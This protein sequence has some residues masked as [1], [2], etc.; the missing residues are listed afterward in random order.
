MVWP[1]TSG[2]TRHALIQ[3]PSSVSATFSPNSMGN[4]SIRPL[5]FSVSFS[6]HSRTRSLVALLFVNLIL[7]HDVHSLTK[8][9]GS[10]L[11][12]HRDVGHHGLRSRFTCILLNIQLDKF[13][14]RLTSLALDGYTIFSHCSWF[15]CALNGSNS[16]EQKRQMDVRKKINFL[17]SL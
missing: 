2:I 11:A 5:S 15:L 9:R 14:F 6:F 16:H 8:N 3:R 4:S 10:F 1:S 7:S 12:I 17:L 13:I